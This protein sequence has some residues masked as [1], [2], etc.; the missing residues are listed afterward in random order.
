MIGLFLLAALPVQTVHLPPV[1][2]S[3]STP[4]RPPAVETVTARL[5]PD[6]VVKEIRVENDSKMHVLVANIGTAD[7][8]DFPVRGSAEI[9]GKSHE[10]NP[11]YVSSLAAGAQS[12]VLLT[13][14]S[15]TPLTAATSATA[16]ADLLPEQQPESTGFFLPGFGIYPG[17]EAW[18]ERTLPG[19]KDRCAKPAKCV[20]EL[21]ETNNSYAIA[22]VPRGTPDRLEAPA[23]APERIPDGG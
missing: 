7:A 4:P 22:G 12:W 10:L 17:N 9:S 3:T 21:D 15:S 2:P 5:L 14:A 19:Y 1:A 8:M 16:G 13:P 18:L 11:G 20:A 6:L 23:S